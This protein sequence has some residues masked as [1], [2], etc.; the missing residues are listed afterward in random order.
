[1]R[2]RGDRKKI[3]IMKDKANISNLTNLY[4]FNLTNVAAF[5]IV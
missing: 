1:M 3:N 2:A 5:G 4:I